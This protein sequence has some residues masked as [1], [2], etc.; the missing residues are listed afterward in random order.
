MNK[1]SDNAKAFV[2]Y[3]LVVCAI[4]AAMQ[5]ADM[6][7]AQFID[8]LDFL[9]FEASYLYEASTYEAIVELF[10]AKA[11]KLDDVAQHVAGHWRPAHRIEGA[12]GTRIFMADIH[13]HV[14]LTQAP[15]DVR[16]GIRLEFDAG[17]ATQ[18]VP[19]L[20]EFAAQG[21]YV[22]SRHPA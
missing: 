19:L 22:T 15:D 7:G 8:F 18:V 17:C 11:V 10:T 16:V 21:F 13:G 12:W 3:A 6:F 2:V 14:Q 20:N 9:E 4:L 5:L 1:M